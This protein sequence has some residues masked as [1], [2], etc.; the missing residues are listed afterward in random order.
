MLIQAPAR[1]LLFFFQKVRAV[2][3]Y[4]SALK[5]YTEGKCPAEWAMVTANLATAHKDR[6]QLLLAEAQSLAGQVRAALECASAAAS[7]SSA[8]A[9][10]EGRLWCGLSARE[11]YADGVSSFF[12]AAA[13][14]GEGGSD[15]AAATVAAMH[16]AAAASRHRASAALEA[17]LRHYEGSLRVYTARSHPEQWALVQNQL[18]REER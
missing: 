10:G 5:V 3:N 12:Q 14:S 17:S 1:C 13:A 8:C 11:R 6:A 18:V 16:G 4:E 2:A 9:R 7:G 15:A